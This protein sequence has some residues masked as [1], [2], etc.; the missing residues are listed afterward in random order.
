MKKMLQKWKNQARGDVIL[1]DMK[2]N[3]HAHLFPVNGVNMFE[4]IGQ[5]G[6]YS[7]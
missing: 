5:V 3:H 2:A 1:I 4:C 6:T 7:K